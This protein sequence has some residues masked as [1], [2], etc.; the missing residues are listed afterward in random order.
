VGVNVPRVL[1]WFTTNI[2]GD[3]YR[4]LRLRLKKQLTQNETESFVQTIFPI[5]IA[6]L[7]FQEIEFFAFIVFPCFVCCLTL[8]FSLFF[9]YVHKSF[10]FGRMTIICLLVTS[11]TIYGY[12]SY[13]CKDEVAGIL[14]R[15]FV[16]LYFLSC[17]LGLCIIVPLKAHFLRA[18]P[19]YALKDSLDR[20]RRLPIICRQL[21]AFDRPP[22]GLM[23]FPSGDAF[24]GTNF[25]IVCWL[26]TGSPYWLICGFLAS[27]GRVYFWVHHVFDVLV[28]SSIGACSV[29]CALYLESLI[30]LGPWQSLMG[31]TLIG[32]VV[33]KTNRKRTQILHMKLEEND[34]TAGRQTRETKYE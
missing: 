7:A 26:L 13:I 34:G 3:I 27:F 22:E 25:G 23:S 4:A 31:W 18:R 32:V 24:I 11:I 1:V 15:R 6:A 16:H 10:L 20:S 30:G 19:A 9:G 33:A 2:S 8:F 14:A 28:G 12:T 21:A 29:W 17:G 5:F